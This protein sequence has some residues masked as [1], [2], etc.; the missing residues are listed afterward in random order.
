MKIFHRLVFPVALVAL[1]THAPSMVIADSANETPDIE[2]RINDLLARM[3]L[4]EKLG[5]MSQ[6]GFPEKLTDKIKGELRSGRWGS[7]YGGAPT[8]DESR[9]FSTSR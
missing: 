8:G 7:F 5:Q 2:V 1:I 4:R 3:T 9:E 6:T